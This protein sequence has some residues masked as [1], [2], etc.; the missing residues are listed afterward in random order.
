MSKK[1]IKI[2]LSIGDHNGIGPEI[3]IK[4]TQVL[5]TNPQVDIVLIGD[6]DVIHFYAKQLD[7]SVTNLPEIIHVPTLESPADLVPGKVCPKAGWA[8]IEYL[9]KAVELSQAGQIDAILA[10]PHNETAVNAAGIAFNGYPGKLAELTHVPRDGVFIMLVGGDLRITHVTLHE[11]LKSAINRISTELIIN[12]GIAS[13]RALEQFG[14]N[15]PK[16]GVFGINP[17]ASEGELFGKEDAQLTF[18]AVKVLQER[19][20]N[21]SE[22]QGADV[23]LAN[24]AHDVYLAMYHDQ[25]HIPIK[26]MYPNQAAAI[27]I[28]TPC[29]FS[30]VAHGTAMDI[31]GTGQ[32]NPAALVNAAEVL[33]GMIR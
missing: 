26:L 32:A 14:F 28:G 25:G 10:C 27:T 5:K 31:A 7:I 33:L 15:E 3:A 17:H 21:V 8:T 12:A 13:I 4:A 23:L 19:G 30:S 11:G 18:P 29:I 20:F 9:K 16:M 2:G 22:P 6:K 24:R 1:H